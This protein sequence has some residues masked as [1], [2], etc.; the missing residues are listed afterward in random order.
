LVAAAANAEARAAY[1]AFRWGLQRQG[2]VDPESD[3]L[4]MRALAN[5]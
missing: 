1:I 2:V 4:V 5:Y 3:P